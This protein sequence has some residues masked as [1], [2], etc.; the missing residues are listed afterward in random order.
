MLKSQSGNFLNAEPSQSG[1]DVEDPETSEIPATRPS[2]LI[3]IAN[4]L[5]VSAV[6]DGQGDWTLQA[7]PYEPDGHDVRP[8][9][10]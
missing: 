7:W 4:R 1:D 6:K 10:L 9:H 5:P 2:R 8:L 3:V